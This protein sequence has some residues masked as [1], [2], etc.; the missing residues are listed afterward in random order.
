M[1]LN[2]RV[3]QVID[4]ILHSKDLIHFVE[5]VCLRE[6]LRAQDGEPNR[7]TPP[8]EMDNRHIS[9]GNSGN[10]WSPEGQ[11][12]S[13]LGRFRW[14]PKVGPNCWNLSMRETIDERGPMK[15]PSSKYQTENRSPSICPTWSNRSRRTREKR[16]GPRRSP[17]WTPAEDLSW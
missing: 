2:L 16:R 8:S 12:I 3:L 5:N 10:D 13:H 17:C 14:R 11:K 7:S 1:E 15:V 6:I 4:M 9:G